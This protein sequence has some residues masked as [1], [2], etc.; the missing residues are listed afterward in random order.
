[1]KP[2]AGIH[3]VY[4]ER[5]IEFGIC[6]LLLLH[7]VKVFAHTK[8]GT[9]LFSRQKANTYLLNP[10]AHLTQLGVLHYA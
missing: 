10:K 4:R 8:K 7:K 5:R 3:Q 1:M 9:R 2:W 6:F